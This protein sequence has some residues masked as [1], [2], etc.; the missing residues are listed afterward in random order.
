MEVQ[1]CSLQNID[2]KRNPMRRVAPSSQKY[3]ASKLVRKRKNEDSDA[4]FMD[5][6]AEHEGRTAL[7]VAVS[8]KKLTVEKATSAR[9]KFSQSKMKKV[10]AIT[11]SVGNKIE[12]SETEPY[13]QRRA[14][15]GPLSISRLSRES[16]RPF[17][18]RAKSLAVE[19]STSDEAEPP[20]I[21]AS[22]PL[23]KKQPTMQQAIAK[24]RK[25]EQKATK[26]QSLWEEQDAEAE[27]D[28]DRG[29]IF[30]TSV[31][32]RRDDWRR[33]RQKTQQN[34]TQ[35]SAK[36]ESNDDI[37]VSA[38][39]R[40]SIGEQAVVGRI[41]EYGVGSE[42][43]I[44]IKVGFGY[45]PSRK[46]YPWRPGYVMP[47]HEV[48]AEGL[49]PPVGGDKII[50]VRVFDDYAT[51][52]WNGPRQVKESETKPYFQ[53]P[54]S[55]MKWDEKRLKSLEKDLDKAMDVD[56]FKR[57]FN[58][59]MKPALEVAFENDRAR[60]R[61]PGRSIHL[62]HPLPSRGNNSGGPS[63]EL[64]TARS[65]EVDGAID[66]AG[67]D[68]DDPADDVRIRL[69]ES[70]R[71]HN[72]CGYVDLL[73]EPSLFSYRGA[74]DL[75]AGLPGPGKEREAYLCDLTSAL[76]ALRTEFAHSPPHLA[77]LT[78]SRNALDAILNDTLV[79]KLRDRER[80][81]I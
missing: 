15:T 57:I 41:R 33:E 16:P 46:T 72:L 8:P 66:G 53:S 11:A 42:R 69:I 80:G 21:S 67:D 55:R 20:P 30:D 45:D 3:V 26:L 70:I 73:L 79:K 34:K 74:R 17:P 14:L 24:R 75:V 71:G 28:D 27:V 19:L 18:S 22:S 6:C 38:S 35:V 40:V 43:L 48:E 44:W 59:G 54:R 29:D 63:K 60:G 81:N 39:N 4:N 12:C 76:T 51:Y 78:T 61:E 65:L 23:P 62:F 13:N 47:T 5:P 1:A 9:A 31:L 10:A 68:D 37:D 49:L 64:A 56:A 7:S 50:W 32:R 52:P 58:N 25:Y 2:T 77:A 36:V